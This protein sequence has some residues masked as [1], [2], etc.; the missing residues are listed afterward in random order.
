MGIF[1]DSNAQKLYTDMHRLTTGVPS[2]KCVIW[3]FC[4]CANVYIYKPR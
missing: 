4:H 3:R 1:S 2:E